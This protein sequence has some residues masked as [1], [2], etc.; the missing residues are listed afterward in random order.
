MK[1]FSIVL[2]ALLSTALPAP[3][4]AQEIQ[5]ATCSSQAQM[6]DAAIREVAY[7]RVLQDGERSA[8]RASV[9]EAQISVLYSEVQ[10]RLLAMILAD[11]GPYQGPLSPRS[12]MRAAQGCIDARLSASGLSRPMAECDRANWQ[13]ASD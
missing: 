3:T 9:S 1:S 13:S 5:P 10:S 4:V 11:C 2:T 6:I 7:M 8:P 12:Y